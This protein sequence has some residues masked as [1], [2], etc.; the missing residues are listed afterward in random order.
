MYRYR[1]LIAGLLYIERPGISMRGAFSVISKF[2][3][4]SER[5]MDMLFLEE[6]ASSKKF[7]NLFTSVVG[8][9]NANVISVEASKTEINL[10]ESDMTVTIES[11]GRRIGLLIEDKID[12][13]AMPDQCERYNLRGDKAVERGDYESY[14]VFIV[15]PEKY[16]SSNLEAAKYPHQISYESIFN[17]FEGIGDQRSAFKIQQ[18]NQA[19]DKQKT[20]YQPI[21]DVRVTNFWHEYSEY[22]KQH[23]P[24]L[25]FVYSGGI[26]GTRS[27]W[28]HFNTVCS[29]LYI[30]HKSNFGVV[31]LNFD[32]CGN[33]LVEIEKLMKNAVPDYLNKGYT[34]QRTGKT[35]V[36]RLTVPVVDFHKAFEEELEN[37]KECFDALRKMNEMVK[38]LNQ[39]DISEIM[40][41]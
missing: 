32:G 23:Y 8:I 16:L 17:Y 37:V 11:E 35:A 36:V 15:A 25:F 2:D 31:D 24:D 22:Q 39:N 26:K 10:G 19:I 12:A 33:K 20:G 29:Q 40:S 41:K 4:V 14:Y 5:D 30:I 38:M 6:F 28:P 13:V 18:I 27:W 34:V 3:D 21:E 9:K 1:P 7:L